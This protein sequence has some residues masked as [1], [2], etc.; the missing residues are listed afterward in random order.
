MMY[1][2]WTCVCLTVSH[3]MF[4]LK[5]NMD[6]A[7]S[8]VLLVLLLPVFVI[9]WISLVTDFLANRSRYNLP[10]TE[11]IMTSSFCGVRMINRSGRTDTC[12]FGISSPEKISFVGAPITEIREDIPVYYKPG[13]TGLRQINEG[14]LVHEKEK[15]MFELHYVQNYSVWMDIDILFRAL[16]VKGR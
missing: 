2:L 4:F 3:G 10:S 12:S 7:L 11:T 16:F 8:A 5:R 13:L 15:Q 9:T 1:R 14:R 6:V